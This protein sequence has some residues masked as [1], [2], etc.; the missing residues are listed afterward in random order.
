MENTSNNSGHRLGR[1]SFLPEPQL[2]AGVFRHRNR[3]QS[4]EDS[5]DRQCKPFV[6]QMCR[7]R[8]REGQ[9]NRVTWLGHDGAPALRHIVLCA[10]FIHSYCYASKTCCTCYVKGTRPKNAGPYGNKASIT[11]SSWSLQNNQLSTT[12]TNPHTSLQGVGKSG[13]PKAPSPA[14]FISGKLKTR[15]SPPVS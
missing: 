8:A 4:W 1:S 3:C 15:K 11:L 9:A 6:I 13:K 2:T 14:L 10:M 12:I 5:W 7:L